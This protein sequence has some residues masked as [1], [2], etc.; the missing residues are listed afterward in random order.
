[1]RFDFDATGIGSLPFKDAKS[2]CRAVLDNIQSIPF[3][4]QLPKRSFLENMYAQFAE[5][6]PGVVID[7]SRR[8]IHV[9]TTGVAETI[10]EV[11]GNFLD[12]NVDFF[13]ISEEFAAGFYEFL[14]ALEKPPAGAKYVKGHITGPISYALS[15]TD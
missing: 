3:W 5:H 15:V 13:R 7:Q 11:Y 9:E 6:L 2:A 12:N 8:T 4:P 1:M 10:E 14:K